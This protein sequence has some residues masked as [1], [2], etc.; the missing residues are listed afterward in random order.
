MVPSR[1]ILIYDLAKYYEDSFCILVY[2]W[3]GNDEDYI[4]QVS[5]ELG[6]NAPCI[7]FNDADLDTAVKGAVCV[8]CYPFVSHVYQ[9]APNGDHTNADI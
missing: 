4:L 2:L 1:N 6:G 9:L 8:S 7:I 3:W 5:L